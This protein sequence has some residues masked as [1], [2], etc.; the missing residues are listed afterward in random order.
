MGF[1]Q[2]RSPPVVFLQQAV[3]A[4][5]PFPAVDWPTPIRAIY[6]VALRTFLLGLNTSTL[7]PAAVAAP[8]AQDDWPLPLS[9]RYPVALRTWLQSPPLTLSGQDRIYGAPGQVPSYD[10]PLP[11]PPQFP[12]GLRTWL[13]GLTTTTLQPTTATPFAQVDWP[14]PLAPIYP[15]ALRTWLHPSR[16]P[17][18]GQDAIYGAPGQVP[19]YEWPLPKTTP[20]PIS[21]RTSLLGLTTT[22][23]A[24]S[25][26]V[27]VLP[28]DWPLPIR[29][30][31]PIALR[32]WLD[33]SKPW[34]VGQDTIYGARGQVPAYDW[35]LPRGPM[36]PVSLRTWVGGLNTTTL[37]PSTA[38]PFTPVEWRNPTRPP[39]PV[40]LLTWLDPS[41]P[42]L[43]GQDRVYGGPGQVPSWDS[44]LPRGPQ[45]PI[46]LRTWLADLVRTTLA[47]TIV[48]FHLTDWPLPGVPLYPVALRTWLKASA[49]QLIG[50]D[51][52]YGAQ[53]QVPSY[54][55][56]LPRGP[57]FSVA[58]RT[59]LSLRREIPS[60]VLT[61][62]TE[63]F[64]VAAQDRTFTVTSE[65]RFIVV[66][67]SQ[68]FAI[69]AQGR[70]IQVSE[71]DRSFEK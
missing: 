46:S 70:F 61:A 9:P 36:Y 50:K 16:A 31:Y 29:P 58:L 54:D 34:L 22:T 1:P 60:G 49:I 68:R 48:P 25:T 6:P 39:Y 23:L 51:T 8:F 55:W 27:P 4:A 2:R 71:Q 3:S 14:T 52:I 26:A 57:Q 42:W 28:I 5:A 40:A 47:P 32:T 38:P 59:W 66:P 41:K 56:P 35:P 63:F 12:V 15:V 62:P 67:P 64:L 17:L 11:K 53:G 10:W 24:P 13:G 7:A 20:Y 44:P 45:F 19:A 18:I 21:L 43:I 65:G 37:I 69:D 30:P 33:P